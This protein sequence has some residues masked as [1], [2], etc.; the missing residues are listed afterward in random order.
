MT[1]A[2]R[3][4]E[5]LRACLARERFVRDRLIARL[6]RQPLAT[7]TSMALSALR[8]ADTCHEAAQALWALSDE[9]RQIER[10]NG[11]FGCDLAAAA[12]LVEAGAS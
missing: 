9:W 1:A 8:Q 3:F 5:S 6:E 11:D 4:G 2:D 7:A 10:T 12:R